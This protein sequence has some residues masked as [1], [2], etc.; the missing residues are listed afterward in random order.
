MAAEWAVTLAPVDLVLGCGIRF[1]CGIRLICGIRFVSSGRRSLVDT[2]IRLEEGTIGAIGILVPEGKPTSMAAASAATLA[3]V[4][5][6]L[7]CG[8]R[9]ICGIRLICGIRFVSSGRSMRNE[10]LVHKAI[11]GHLEWAN[12]TARKVTRQES[13]GTKLI[14]PRDKA[15]TH[16]LHHFHLF[17][18]LI[19]EQQAAHALTI[20]CGVEIDYCGSALNE[21]IFLFSIDVV[22]VIRHMALLVRHRNHGLFQLVPVSM[23]SALQT[24]LHGLLDC[25]PSEQPGR[26][27]LLLLTRQQDPRLLICQEIV[28]DL[29]A[30]QT[31]IVAIGS[32]NRSGQDQEPPPLHRENMGYAMM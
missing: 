4:D 9:F 32:L 15:F 25:M 3:P 23:D 24:A 28:D 13:V 31:R 21:A 19:L 1:I 12:Q 20:W 6:V 29:D 14:V 17:T 22:L 10:H 18:V 7:G 5:L 26:Q 27:D 11:T 16:G 30:R 2:V 8:I